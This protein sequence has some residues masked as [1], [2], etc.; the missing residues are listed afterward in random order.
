M[1]GMLRRFVVLTLAC[2]S[3]MAVMAGC[4]PQTSA[5][6]TKAKYQQGAKDPAE[7]QENR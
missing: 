6:E 5:E 2:A 7:A 4:N 1:A 3:A